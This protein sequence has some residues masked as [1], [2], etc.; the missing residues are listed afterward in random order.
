VPQGFVRG[1]EQIAPL[2]RPPVAG[3]GAEFL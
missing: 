3:D 2:K 1:G